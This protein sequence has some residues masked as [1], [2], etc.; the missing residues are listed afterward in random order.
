[1]INALELSVPPTARNRGGGQN[2]TGMKLSVSQ[3]Q[4]D[5]RAHVLLLAKNG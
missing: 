1:M 3:K 4:R 5:K 2:G